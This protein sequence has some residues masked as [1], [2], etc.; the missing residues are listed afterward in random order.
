MDFWDQSGDEDGSGDDD[1]DGL[2]SKKKRRK[3]SAKKEK[4]DPDDA[5]D[6]AKEESDEGDFEQRE[7][8]YMSD[9]SSSKSSHQEEEAKDENDVKGIAEEEALRDLLSTDDEEDAEHALQ[10][11][12]KSS[13]NKTTLGTVEFKQDSEGNGSDESSDSDD[14]DVDEEKMD[15]MFNKKGLPTQLASIKQEIKQEVDS[16]AN[17]G[18]TSGIAASSTNRQQSSV[19]KRKTAPEIPTPSSQPATKR[20]CTTETSSSASVNSQE[21]IVEDLVRKYLSRKPMTLKTLLKDIKS[22]LKK[23]EGVIPELDNN[24]VHTIANIIRRI[25][26][27]RQ[28]INNIDY[29]SLKS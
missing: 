26:P 25:N 9:T 10:K 17:G 22:K 13:S 1:E 3:K 28:K 27:D 24:L 6:E 18:S 8:D 14:Y 19:N 11:G 5:P 12:V 7:V 4:E 23:M 29:F 16:G 20:P 21:K 2:D 15:S